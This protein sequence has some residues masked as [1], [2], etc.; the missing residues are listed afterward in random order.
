[1]THEKACGK[2]GEMLAEYDFSKG[3]RGKYARRH[4]RG[5]NVVVLDPDV[6][7]LFP[8]CGGRKQ[9]VAR[10]GRDYSPTEVARSQV[11]SRRGAA[12]TTSAAATPKVFAS[13]SPRRASFG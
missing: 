13:H 2:K 3:A 11:G 5:S 8:K 4:A 6:A 1:M 12:A 7:E 9:F 10:P